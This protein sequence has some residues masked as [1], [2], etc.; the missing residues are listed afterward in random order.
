M[1]L[2]ATERTAQ[3]PTPRVAG[4]SEKKY[5]AMPTSGSAPAQLRLGKENRSQQHV[6]PQNQGR[7]RAAAIPVRGK[8]EILR[9]LDCKK[10]RLWLWTLTQFKRPLSYRNRS[11]PSRRDKGFSFAARQLLPA[12][13]PGWLS[14]SLEKNSLPKTARLRGGSLSVSK[15]GSLSVSANAKMRIAGMP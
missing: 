7:D 4:V 2:P 14:A 15:P 5:P 1:S 8:P 12:R 3:I 10:P 13:R 9:D 6:I 11:M